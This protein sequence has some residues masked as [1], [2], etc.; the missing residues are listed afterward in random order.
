MALFDFSSTHRRLKATADGI[1]NGGGNARVLRGGSWNNN[2][3]I[4]LRSS[5][6]NNDQPKKLSDH[7]PG[8]CGSCNLV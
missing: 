2:A 7:E 5:Y 6:R 3:E 4:N 1:G 8:V